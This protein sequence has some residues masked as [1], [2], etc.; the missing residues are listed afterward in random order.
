MDRVIDG[1]SKTVVTDR[2]VPLPV[3][4]DGCVTTET[5][6][7][8]SPFQVKD[9]AS[10]WIVLCHSLILHAVMLQAAE[11]AAA[12]EAAQAQEAGDQPTEEA[13]EAE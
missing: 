12:L 7:L 8:S 2:S 4:C 1:V 3:T 10:L 11:E 5:K 9:V 6:M 13:E